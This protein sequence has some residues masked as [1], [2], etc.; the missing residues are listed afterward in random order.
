MSWFK[1][2]SHRERKQRGEAYLTIYHPINELIGW[3]I[4]YITVE[5]MRGVIW[6]YL[7]HPRI[8]WVITPP[9]LPRI[10]GT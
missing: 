7:P 2:F 10:L 1:R 8:L 9:P 3:S 5:Y 6:G 4:V